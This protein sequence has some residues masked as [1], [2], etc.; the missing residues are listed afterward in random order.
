MVVLY[1]ISKFGANPGTVQRLI[2]K[3]ILQGVL[4]TGKFRYMMLGGGGQIV[5]LIK[6]FLGFVMRV[7]GE[8]LTEIYLIYP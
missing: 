6:I 1:N 5:M 7:R 2:L 3:K 4:S 8:N